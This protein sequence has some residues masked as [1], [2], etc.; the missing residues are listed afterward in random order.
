ME[1]RAYQLEALRA[2]LREW[3]TVKRTLLVL[4]TGTGKTI[5]FS[6]LAK[7]LTDAG[8]RVMILAHREELIDQA[9]DKLYRATG[10]LPAKKWQSTKRTGARAS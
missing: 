8:K 6:H 9:I 3:R 1:L 7:R 2:V 5:V 10:I 4:P